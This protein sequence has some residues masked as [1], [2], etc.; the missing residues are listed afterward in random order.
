MKLPGSDKHTARRKFG[1]LIFGSVLILVGLAVVVVVGI[2]Y[3]LG[4]YNSTQLDGL[5]AAVQG[6]IAMPSVETE[7]TQIRGALMPDGSFK[8]IHSVVKDVEAYVGDRKIDE[9]AP[10]VAKPSPVAAVTAPNV[11]ASAG[12]R[13]ELVTTAIPSAEQTT[14]DERA[15]PASPAEAIDG[16]DLVFAYNALYPGYQVHPKYWD[17]PL[18]AGADPYAYGVVKRPDGFVSI[19]SSQGMPRGSAS[20]ANHI[21]IS[22]IGVDSTVSN[23]AI[24]DVGD[25]R[26]YETPKHVVGRIPETSNP[27]ELGN[28]WLFGHLESP[29]RGEGNVF[30][31]LPEIPALL[32][33]GD[34]VYVSLLNE[35]GDE[36]LYQIT[37]T[38]VVH[39]DDLE[40]YQTDD[41]TIT[42]V[43]CVPRLVYDRRLL[44]TGKLVGV[45]KAA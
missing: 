30:Q 42:L 26:Q 24:I 36:F 3:G 2:Y 9:R 5:N 18:S 22:S 13:A 27:G 23:L 7:A 25:S 21:R 20:D 28:T 10:E 31:K 8:P 45:K 19:E 17:N 37:A 43:S 12:A 35:D 14:A 33:S 16:A 1:K 34:P 39:E 4:R 44:V 29:I 41:S 32:N 15:T 11:Q 40:L 6:P 38:E